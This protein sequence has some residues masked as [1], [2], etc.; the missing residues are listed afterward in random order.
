MDAIEEWRDVKGFEGLYKVSNLGS[1]KSMPKDFYLP[2]NKSYHHL[3]EKIIYQGAWRGYKQIRLCKNGKKYMRSAHIIVATAFCKKNGRALTVNH[4]DGNKLNNKA[5]NLEWMTLS[6]NHKHA[7][8]IGLRCNDGSMNPI[9]KLI[10]KDVN[11]IKRLY[12]Y[13]NLKQKD[14][15]SLYCVTP[16]VI[17]RIIKGKSW[18]HVKQTG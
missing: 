8:K 14:I 6:D 17:C 15:A 18:R 12:S 10:E 7:F 16:T 2:K 5:D 13:Y 1:I 11:I 4:K 9:H 3:K